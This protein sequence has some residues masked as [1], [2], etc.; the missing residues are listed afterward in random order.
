MPVDN[1]GVILGLERAEGSVGV[2]AELDST[3]TLEEGVGPA[4]GG[5]L[6]LAVELGCAP[7]DVIID[8][9][10][11]ETENTPVPGVTLL[12]VP[13]GPIVGRLAL[14]NGNGADGEVV[15]ILRLVINV[16]ELFGTTLDVKFRMA[17]LLGKIPVLVISPVMVGRDIADDSVMFDVVAG[18]LDVTFS[19][20]LADVEYPVLRAET[21]WLELPIG[22]GAV[23]VLVAVAMGDESEVSTEFI[24]IEPVE[25]TVKLVELDTVFDAGVC[26]EVKDTLLLDSPL[27]VGPL[28]EYEE[29]V[30]GKGAVEVEPNAFE[31]ADEVGTDNVEPVFSELEILEGP[32]EMNELVPVGPTEDSVVTFVSGKGVSWLMSSEP[33]RLLVDVKLN[34]VITLPSV[35]GVFVG[36]IVDDALVKEKIDVTL[37]FNKLERLGNIEPEV[38]VGPAADVVPLKFSSE[39]LDGPM[40][41]GT[42]I[43]VIVG[44]LLLK[45]TLPPLNEL[46]VTLSVV[47]E[48]FGKGYGVV[49]L[50]LASDTVSNAELTPEGDEVP[51]VIEL[52]PGLDVGTDELIG[53]GV[54][55]LVLANGP[56]VKVNSD[57]EVV[58]PAPFDSLIVS[59]IT[60]TEEFNTEKLVVSLT[61]V[62]GTVL[63]FKPPVEI[64]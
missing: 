31:L 47:A 43:D 16:S 8:K 44:M 62:D 6:P 32:V 59:L 51:P 26:S 60:V 19:V 35:K 40:L 27:A 53:N 48:E 39:L 3:S 54:G 38:K 28:I 20:P 5:T 4:S 30:N 45:E 34:V 22:Y 25:V 9:A 61:A 63:E 33:G 57:I 15:G 7:E 2:T 36:P 12:S 52:S 1:D 17:E 11:D 29:F 10:I 49:W 24:D 23:G 37:P 56:V 64:S 13:D 14:D 50:I 41:V 42:G 18:R 58:E 21:G 46:L 55:W